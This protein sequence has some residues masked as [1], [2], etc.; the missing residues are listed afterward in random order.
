[1]PFAPQ[2]F[3]LSADSQTAVSRTDPRPAAMAD[4][5]QPHTTVVLAEWGLGQGS[6]VLATREQVALVQ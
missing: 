6:L 4:H 2:L 1:M 5:V 3:L